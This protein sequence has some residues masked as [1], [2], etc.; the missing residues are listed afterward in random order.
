MLT[1]SQISRRLFSSAVCLV[2]GFCLNV[3]PTFAATITF[4]TPKWI[5]GDTDVITTGTLKYAYCWADTSGGAHTTTLNGVTFTNSKEYYKTPGTNPDV[6]SPDMT[7][8]GGPGLGFSGCSYNPTAPSCALSAAYQKFLDG[9]FQMTGGGAGNF[10]LHN[11]TVGHKYLIQLWNCISGWGESRP[12]YYTTPGGDTMVLQC[13]VDAV[14]GTLGQFGSGTFTADSTNQT[15]HIFPSATYAARF[16]G[17]QVR[18]ISGNLSVTINQAAGQADPTTGPINF[19]VVFSSAVS[20][21]TNGDVTVTTAGGPALTQTITG[22]GTT[23]NVALSGMTL[24]TG[25]ITASIAAGV[26]HNDSAK[27]NEASTSTD[28]SVTYGTIPP[29]IITW[30]TPAYVAGN[31][32]ISTTGTFKYAYNWGGAT[33][34]INGVTF[35]GTTSAGNIGSSPYDITMA[36]A[37]GNG[38]TTPLVE[39]IFQSPDG[40]TGDYGTEL[41]PGGAYVDGTDKILVTL[42][43]LTSGHTY[44]VQ[45]WSENAYYDGGKTILICGDTVTLDKNQNDGWA[46]KGQYVTG[47]FTAGQNGPTITIA[48]TQGPGGDKAGILNALQ[49]RELPATGAVIRNRN[50]ATSAANNFGKTL[51]YD[52]RGRVVGISENGKLPKSNRAGIYLLKSAVSGKTGERCVIR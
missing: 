42:N 47:T 27:A 20:D 34:T 35:T 12:A 43:N 31:S 16:C 40:I 24:A 19:T 17:V 1:L 21:F 32:D 50:I 3:V 45:I 38:W 8:G 41:L 5:K 49:V 9:A 44:Q 7:P 36:S 10:T 39:K 25:T 23:Y 29:N 6:T 37:P 18:D 2:A 33:V 15:I 22:G 11:L 30:G 28:N 4:G 14:P 46:G 51:I 26:A 48:G 52:V 13:N